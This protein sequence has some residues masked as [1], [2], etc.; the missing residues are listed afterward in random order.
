MCYLVGYYVIHLLLNNLH[1]DNSVASLN[2]ITLF[3]CI[4]L[5]CEFDTIS[6]NILHVHIIRILS[7]PYNIVMV[8]NKTST[9]IQ[10]NIRPLTTTKP[11]LNV[12]AQLTIRVYLT[13]VARPHS[14][15]GFFD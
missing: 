6:H 15:G 2:D 5:F 9:Q 1:I 13:K 10:F 11:R 14:Q 3:R 4:I 8:L 12:S 7:V